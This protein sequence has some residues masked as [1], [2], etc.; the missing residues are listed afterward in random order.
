M[1]QKILVVDDEQDI[2]T[3]FQ[4]VLEPHQIVVHS[5]TTGEAALESV[6]ENKPDVIFLDLR[7][8]GIDGFQ[9]LKQLREIDS[10]LL[11]ILMTA[12]TT[13]DTV[14]EAMK[15]GA[16]DFIG[17]PFTADKLRETTQQALKVA[18]DMK[19]VV[20][21]D[22]FS[23]KGFDFNRELIIGNSEAMQGVYKS[24]GQVATSNATVLITGESGTG[25]ELVARA[26][27]HHSERSE[28]AF[29]AVNCA[30]IP[31][32]LLESELF[33]HEKGSFTGAVSRK[34]GKFEVARNG[35]IF[36]DEIGDM[37]LSTQTKILRVL[38]DG[39]FQ[40][41]GGNDELKS[42]VRIL[43]ATNRNL[44]QM[45]KEGSFRADLY[46]RLNVVHIEMP[47]LR[48]RQ[49][50]I[51]ALI[52]YFLKRTQHENPKMDIPSFSQE[53]L[54]ELINHHWPG[55]V[56]ELENVVSNLV[57]TS[58]TEAI[59]KSDIKLKAHV[60]SMPEKPGKSGTNSQAAEDSEDTSLSISPELEIE[61]M[62][63]RIF[64]KLIEFRDE[65]PDLNTFDL[66][67]RAL[68]VHALTKTKGNQVKAAKLLGITRSTLRKRI[69]RYQIEIK[70]SIRG[71]S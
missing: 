3:G 64:E 50:D 23:K 8:P 63:Q 65:F 42:D 70:T 57:L 49:D 17:K 30:A 54:D 14:I 33:G 13:T 11:I 32:N 20:S 46:Y 56:R 53:A 29:V 61:A 55:N 62:T 21:F 12:Y 15:S 18:R 4:R 9:T 1:K 7:L 22:S 31:E 27:Y 41:V 5:A 34:L 67:E 37:T 52:D 68:I 59:L 16:Y 28:Q 24:I 35:T 69:A 45:V 26:M 10:K 19:K 47:P 38:Q 25:K 6:R 43:A 71:I 39:T 48:E 44:E 66:V 2:I 58:K 40:R 60:E 51:P 36:L